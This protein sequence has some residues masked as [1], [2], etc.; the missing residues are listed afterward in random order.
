MLSGKS[1]FPFSFY[2]VFRLAEQH[3]FGR[4]LGA[5]PASLPV[6]EAARQDAETTRWTHHKP[7]AAWRLSREKAAPEG[8]QNEGG[9]PRGLSVEARRTQN[10]LEV[11]RL[12][13]ARRSSE[14]REAVAA[15]QELKHRRP[16]QETEA[17]L[18]TGQ[19]ATVH[20]LL[21]LKFKSH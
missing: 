3:S 4:T 5:N 15:L 11:G 17:S 6:Q 12:A 7:E 8:L 9:P 14:D 20:S 16:R 13:A 21:K 10:E 2:T 18:Q 19:L 1:S